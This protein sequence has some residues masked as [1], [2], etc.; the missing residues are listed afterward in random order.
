MNFPKI[1]WGHET[2]ASP[3]SEPMLRESFYENQQLFTCENRHVF[4]L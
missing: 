2:P 3:M 1:P 4:P